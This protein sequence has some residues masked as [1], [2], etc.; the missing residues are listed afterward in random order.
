MAH[1]LVWFVVHGKFP[2]GDIDH[3]NGNR[4]D[5]RIENLRDVTRRA[6][7]QNVIKRPRNDPTLPTGINVVHNKFREIQGYYAHW[8]D[9]DGKM[10]QVYFGLRRCCTLEAALDAAIARREL[11]IANL[12]KLGASYTERHGVE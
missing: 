5:N 4:S 2:D 9:M 8:Q 10:Q 6:N 3:I 11:E 7:L 12:N 1:R